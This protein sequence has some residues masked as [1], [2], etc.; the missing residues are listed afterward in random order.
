MAFFSIL[1]LQ[2][3]TRTSKI[4]TMKRTGLIITIAVVV[5]MVGAITV[6]LATSDNSPSTTSTEY[7]ER[8]EAGKLTE[9]MVGVTPASYDE[10]ITNSKGVVV[11]DYFAP[12]CSYCIKYTPVFSSVF[13]QYRDKAVFGKFDVTTDRTKIAAHNISGTPATL[14]FRDG[15]EVGRID[16]YVE[17]AVLKAKLDE[18]LAQ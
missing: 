1:T 5:L 10:K 18:V 17:E 7:R 8:G 4:D 6:K 11:I 12:T 15:V 9:G 3:A 14:I 2:I 13:Q 16:G